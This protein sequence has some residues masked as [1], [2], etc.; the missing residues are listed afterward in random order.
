M[1]MGFHVLVKKGM[2]SGCLSAWCG[3]RVGSQAL[4]PTRLLLVILSR[5]LWRAGL[6]WDRFSVFFILAHSSSRLT[7]THLEASQIIFIDMLDQ[8]SVNHNQWLNP[9]D[10]GSIFMALELKIFLHLLKAYKN[11]WTKQI[12]KTKKDVQWGPRS[13]NYLRSGPLWI[14]L[15]E[16]VLDRS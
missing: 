7:W 15:A 16:A 6:L 3:H 13:L 5:S 12:I 2:E 4:E 9:L 8:G 11:Q 14:P 10:S 1:V